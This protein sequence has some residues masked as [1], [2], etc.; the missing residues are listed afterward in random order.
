MIRLL[1]VVG[2]AGVRRGDVVFSQ[3][4]SVLIAEE[5]DPA[6]RR[7][8]RCRSAS[9]W[10]RPGMRRT[11][12]RIE[13]AESGQDD[14]RAIAAQ[15]GSSLSSRSAIDSE[16]ARRAATPGMLWRVDLL[17]GSRRWIVRSQRYSVI[18]VRV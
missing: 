7:R 13:D 11:A 6:D 10:P 9:S 15:L 12:G 8:R 14:R 17:S 4:L 5:L 2:Q 16:A 3:S 1:D 18:S